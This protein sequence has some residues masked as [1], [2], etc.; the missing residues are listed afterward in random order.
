MLKKLWNLIRG[1]KPQ[2]A[3]PVRVQPV[4]SAPVS[5]TKMVWN[6]VGCEMPSSIPLYQVLSIYESLGHKPRSSGCACCYY[7]QN[8][9]RELLDDLRTESSFT[10]R[11]ANAPGERP[12]TGDTR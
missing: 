12:A 6:T 5:K 9:D 1:Q 8:C 2:S 7:C 3:A 4:V 10:K 11:C